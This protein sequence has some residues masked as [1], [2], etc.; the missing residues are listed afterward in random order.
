VDKREGLGG[1]KRL[2]KINGWRV[3]KGAQSEED[4]GLERYESWEM[5]RIGK[6]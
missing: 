2:Q 3:G 4:E 6:E 1:L 5:M